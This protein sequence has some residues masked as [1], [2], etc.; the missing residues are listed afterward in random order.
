MRAFSLTRSFSFGFV[1]VLL[2]RGASSQLYIILSCKSTVYTGATLSSAFIN[3]D[4]GVSSVMKTAWRLCASVTLVKSPENVLST[5][6]TY[7]VDTDGRTIPC[8]VA[9]AYD[10]RADFCVTK[11]FVEWPCIC[12]DEPNIAA[13]G[14]ALT[15]GWELSERRGKPT[16]HSPST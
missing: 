4:L 7:N 8:Q 14:V 12:G 5:T 13:I 2:T 15:R 6:S 3:N 11:C 16:L 10:I 1:D 9:F